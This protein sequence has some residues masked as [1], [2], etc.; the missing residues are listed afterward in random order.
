MTQIIRAVYEGGVL[1]PLDSLSLAERQHVTIT[2]QSP[3]S[4]APLDVIDD[5]LSGLRVGTGIVDLA[6]HFDEYRH[7][8]RQP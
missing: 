7:G 1:R 2:V 8:T 3:D 5:P 4:A 6:E